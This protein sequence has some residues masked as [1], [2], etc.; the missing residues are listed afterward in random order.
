MYSTATLLLNSNSVTSHKSLS[1]SFKLRQLLD[2][3]LAGPLYSL[4]VSFYVEM[5]LLLP[6]IS[7]GNRV[8]LFRN[9]LNEI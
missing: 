4:S 6:F 1:Q 5:Y 9:I 8:I 3:T 7:K 2:C